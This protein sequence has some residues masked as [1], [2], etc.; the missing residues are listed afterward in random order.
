[1]N[2]YQFGLFERLEDGFAVGFE[3]VGEE[4]LVVAELGT[5]RQEYMWL[6]LCQVMDEK[7]RRI[8]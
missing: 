7:L 2:R 5:G 1:M 3:R 4:D 6:A 8:C